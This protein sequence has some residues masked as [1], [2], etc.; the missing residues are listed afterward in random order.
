MLHI[1]GTASKLHVL[2]S[3][4]A[5]GTSAEATTKM[6]MVLM[7]LQLK[8]TLVLLMH[9]LGRCARI[10]WLRLS[11]SR[12]VLTQLLTFTGLLWTSTNP[13]FTPKQ[14]FATEP[15]ISHS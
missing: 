1:L 8:S 3:T 12:G 9:M 6:H 13:F 15:P 14:A 2:W 11:R 10:T 7:R 4:W 5:M